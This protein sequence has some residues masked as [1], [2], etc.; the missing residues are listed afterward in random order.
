MV[1]K[2]LQNLLGLVCACTRL[3]LFQSKLLLEIIDRLVDRFNVIAVELIQSIFNGSAFALR[4]R[5]LI[6]AI[7]HTTR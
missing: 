5:H 7:W 4:Y 2:D 6:F 1:P 3:K